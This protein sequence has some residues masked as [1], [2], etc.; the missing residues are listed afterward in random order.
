M[1]GSFIIFDRNISFETALISY[2]FFLP[3]FAVIYS[4]LSNSTLFPAAHLWSIGVEEIFYLL[5]PVVLLKSKQIINTLSSLTIGYYFLPILFLLLYKILK[6]K[7]LVLILMCIS[8]NSFS[9]MLLGAITAYLYINY[10]QKVLQFCNKYI[11]LSALVLFITMIA[12]SIFF[13]WFIRE[14]YSL[15]FCII[16]IYA[17]EHKTILLENKVF[18]YL[19]K[20]SYGIYIY[21]NFVIAIILYQI[22]QNSYNTESIYSRILI[23]IT[24]TILTVLIAAISY[25][26]YEKRFLNLKSRINAVQ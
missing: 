11:A 20:I 8:V 21:H 15:L 25:E 2:L 16:M 22:K 19:G 7:L 13:F 18:S 10:H 9:C 3:Q 23:T 26:F 24:V 17:I 1:T 12:K 5:I 4:G 6:Y 14:L